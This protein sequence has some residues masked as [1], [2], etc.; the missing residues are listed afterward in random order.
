MQH[1]SNK[2]N[3]KLV[4]IITGLDFQSEETS[5][6]LNKE[7][8]EVFFIMSQAFNVVE[9]EDDSYISMYDLDEKQI[10]TARDILK[11]EEGIK[12]IPLPSEFDV[13]EWE[14]MKN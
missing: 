13:H 5:T 9:E 1:D 6:Y 8:G 14:I 10:E 3:I 11:D 4:D 7:T 12:Y 2:S